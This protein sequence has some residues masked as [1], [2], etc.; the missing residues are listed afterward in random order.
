[1]NQL[2][3]V[4]MSGAPGAGKT[5]VARAIG[6]ATG[7]VVIDHD[8]TKSALLAADVPVDL[9][10][11]ASYQVLNAMAS[12]L[13]QQ[14]H[15]VIFDS[16]CFY[17]ELLER[18]QRLAA[19][20]GA[21][22]RYIECVLNDLTELDRRLRTRE[23][24]PSQVAGVYA[25]PTAGSGKTESGE[26]LFQGW[27]ARMKRPHGKYLTLDTTLPADQWIAHAIRYVTDG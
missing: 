27:I 19:E 24:M 3:F 10:G 23:R 6:K 8:V 4:Q 2:F 1:M 14:G 25:Q 7:A 11:R 26:V 20:S 16:P 9:A 22:Y 18:G 17:E 15:S 21:T 12:H 5:T 13:L